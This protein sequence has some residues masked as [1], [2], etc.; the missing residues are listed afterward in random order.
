MGMNTTFLFYNSWWRNL[1]L[2][3]ISAPFFLAPLLV[4]FNDIFQD[5]WLL[6]GFIMF[7]FGTIVFGFRFLDRRIKVKISELGVHDYRTR[8]GNIP[9]SEI[10]QYRLWSVKGNDY[11][12]L[13]LR[14]PQLWITRANALSRVIFG[15]MG[16]NKFKITIS[17][18]NMAVNEASLTSFMT[19]MVALASTHAQQGIQPDAPAFGGSAG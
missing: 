5:K 11:I 4:G 14:S 13:T 3:L 16:K 15:V 9:W 19:K 6:L 7:G 12:T 2:T 17:L 8:Y 1:A 18:Q 10:S